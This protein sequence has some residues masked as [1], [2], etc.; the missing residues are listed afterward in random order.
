MVD[1]VIYSLGQMSPPSVL[2]VSEETIDSVIH[3]LV[4][5]E[6]GFCH[7]EGQSGQAM[8]NTCPGLD[9]P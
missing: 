3:L 2:T 6:T 1:M 8:M 4:N 7:S 9:L 5:D